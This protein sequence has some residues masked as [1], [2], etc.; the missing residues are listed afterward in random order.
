MPSEPCPQL[1]C[2]KPLLVEVEEGLAVATVV[3]ELGAPPLPVIATAVEEGRTD[4]ETTAP[5]G[6]GAT[7]WG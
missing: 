1:L 2:A 3:E 6:I 4:A 5:S 7:G